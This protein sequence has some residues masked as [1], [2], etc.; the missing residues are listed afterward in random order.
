MKR[1]VL[2]LLGLTLLPL[3]VAVA[4]A[5]GERLRDPLAAID[6]DPGAV[7]VVRDSSYSVLTTAGEPRVFRDLTLQ[8]EGAGLVRVT[9]SRPADPP[10]GP[11]PLVLVLAGLRTGR[12]ALGYIDAHGPN[13]LVGYQYPYDQETWYQGTRVAQVPVIRKAVLDVPAQVALVA[14]RLAGDPAVDTSRTALLGYSFGAMFVPAAQRLAAARGRPFHALILAYGG[15]GIASLVEANLK[16]EPGFARRGLAWVGATAVHPMEP[17][18]HLPHLPGRFLLVIGEEDE[19]IPR[20]AAERMVRLTPEPKDVVVLD[21]GH[22][23]PGRAELTSRVVRISQDW[24]AD[25]G[26]IEPPDR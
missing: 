7:R 10:D 11:M 13:V 6:R 9:T 3:T 25:Q 8:T 22:M 20:A 17:A 2:V 26:I 12:D 14:E 5:V 23:R 19:Q 16:V 24:L 18:H 1:V 4:W 21:A 15:A